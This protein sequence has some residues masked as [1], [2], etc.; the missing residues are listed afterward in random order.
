VQGD[1]AG[2]EIMAT[3]IAAVRRTPTIRVIEGLVVQDLLVDGRYVTGIEAAV[4]GGGQSPVAIP[5]RAVVLASGGIGGLYAVTTNPREAR[6]SGLAVAARAGAVIADA[7]F[8]QFHPTALDVGRDPAPLATEALRGEGATLV[9][10]KG[11][12]FMQKLDPAAELAPR[13]VVARGVFAELQSGRGAFLDVRMIDGFARRFPTVHAACAEAGLDPAAAPIPVAPAAHYHMGG[14]L[15][16]ANGRSSLD[17]LW[18]IGEVAST[19]AHGANRLASN[20]LLEALVFAARAAEDISGL[21]PLP[22]T[23]GWPRSRRKPVAAH[24]HP[25]SEA[26]NKLRRLMAEDVGVVRTGSGL[27]RAVTRLAAIEQA[28]P[29][30]RL[31]DMAAAGLIIAAAAL[32]RTESR[33]AHYRADFPKSDPAQARRSFFTLDEVRAVASRAA[34]KAA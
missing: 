11:E 7:E 27:A 9:N 28:A 33:G 22:K 21:L 26:E 19:G 30:A 12:R 14:V 17:G 4:A 18:A 24:D 6:G 31:R 10:R 5:A 13:D 34:A 2:A 1:R 25:G 3:L 20:S 15:A 32:R 8:V 23:L 16:D 29:S